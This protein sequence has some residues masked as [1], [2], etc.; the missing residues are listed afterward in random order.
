MADHTPARHERECTC[1]VV[2]GSPHLLFLC[3]FITSIAR[4]LAH[5]SLKICFFSE[6]PFHAQGPEHE[7]SVSSVIFKRLKINE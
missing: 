7:T 4:G 5:T 6:A 2:G 3:A 1:W